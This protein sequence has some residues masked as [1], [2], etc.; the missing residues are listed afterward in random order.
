MMAEL[1]YDAL[2]LDD[3]A[4]APVDPDRLAARQ[5]SE[6]LY[7]GRRGGYLNNVFFVPRTA[8]TH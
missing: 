8:T 3:G 5:T 2:A 4:L 6:L 7:A 1:D